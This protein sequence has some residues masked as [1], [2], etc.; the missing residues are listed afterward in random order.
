MKCNAQ[1][2]TLLIRIG[3][4]QASIQPHR[5]VYVISCHSSTP[6]HSPVGPRVGAGGDFPILFIGNPSK[7]NHFVSSPSG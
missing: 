5:K 2:Q 1:P 6:P 4:A 3:C 7:G